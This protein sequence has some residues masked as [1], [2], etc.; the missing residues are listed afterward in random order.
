MNQNHFWWS[1][2]FTSRYNLSAQYSTTS[3]ELIT[4]TVRHKSVKPVSDSLMAPRPGARSVGAMRSEENQHETAHRPMR[5]NTRIVC[6][7]LRCVLSVAAVLALDTTC[8]RSATVLPAQAGFATGPPGRAGKLTAAFMAHPLLSLPARSTTLRG[9]RGALCSLVAQGAAAPPARPVAQPRS[10]DAEAL[11][12]RIPDSMRATT[13]IGASEVTATHGGLGGLASYGRT[14][15]GDNK[16]ADGSDESEASARGGSVV[17]KKAGRASPPP[18][19]KETRRT[20]L[21]PAMLGLPA[22]P[23]RTCAGQQALHVEVLTSAGGAQ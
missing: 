17:L 10:S 7:S 18:P 1:V 15:S 8:V 4:P 20:S 19:C 6:A 22:R 23:A 12:P 14:R 3:G 9:D 16:P 5:A 13:A 21:A 11:I 2:A